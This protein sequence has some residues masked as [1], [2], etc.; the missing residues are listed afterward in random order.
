MKQKQFLWK[1]IS[2]KK[3]CWQKRE[4]TVC[5]ERARPWEKEGGGGFVDEIKKPIMMSQLLASSQSC[6]VRGG[7][8]GGFQGAFFS[9]PFSRLKLS[10]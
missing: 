7:G 5:P 4:N 9:A 2:F 3:L 1:N 10:F 6:D 8:G